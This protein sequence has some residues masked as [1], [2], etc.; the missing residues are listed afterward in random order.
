MNKK[1][2]VAIVDD[3]SLFRKGIRSLLDEYGELEIITEVSNG[4]LLLES[5]KIKKPDVILLD[6][7]MPIM[8]GAETVSVL[9]LK[10]PEIKIIILTMHN[11]DGLIINLLERGVNGFLPKDTDIEIVVDAIYSVIE[12]DYYFND[13][14]SRTLVKKLASSKKINPAFKKSLLTDREIEIVKYICKEFTNKE[15]A[16]KLFLSPRTIDTYR[17][18]ILEKTGAK[19]TAG[20]VMYAVKNKMVE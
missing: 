14:I 15:I 13:H 19:N 7:E 5:L 8:D 17:E 11:E 18:K 1:I 16:E 4:K 9:K 10:Y 12:T 20:I 3:H 6:L 2:S